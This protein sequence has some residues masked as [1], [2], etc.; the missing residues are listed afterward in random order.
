[1]SDKQTNTQILK[2]KN[3]QEESWEKLRLKNFFMEKQ[4]IVN[5]F[6]EM[7]NND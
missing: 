6:D 4:M 3:V 7:K 5:G 1:M 2:W